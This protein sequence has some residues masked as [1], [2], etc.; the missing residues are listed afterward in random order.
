VLDGSNVGQLDCLARD[1][2]RGW[3]QLARRHLLQQAIWKGLQPR[4]LHRRFGV[5]RWLECRRPKVGRHDTPW[6]TSERGQT[7]VRG[8]AIEPGPNER[9]AV[10]SGPAAPRAHE[11][12]LHQVL[13]LLERAEHAVA[14][15]EKLPSIAFDERGKRRLVSELQACSGV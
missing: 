6:P 1:D 10:E 9:A 13:G 15:H 7:D 2:R 14:M 5:V 12:L 4:D 11:R 8:D 3:L